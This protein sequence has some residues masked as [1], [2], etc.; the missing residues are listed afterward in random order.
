VSFSCSEKFVHSI[1]ERSR[2]PQHTPDKWRPSMASPLLWDKT[3]QNW[4]AQYLAGSEKPDVRR[5]RWSCHLTHLNLLTRS[6]CPQ[7][8]NDVRRRP[9]YTMR[10]RRSSCPDH[11]SPS[12]R[13]PRSAGQCHRLAAAAGKPSRQYDEDKSADC[14]NAVDC[15]KDNQ[16]YCQTLISS[17]WGYHNQRQLAFNT[18][19][20]TVCTNYL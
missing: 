14:G 13:I 11:D 8:V 12:T 7:R 3:K 9:S 19:P 5:G 4:G 20:F 6:S 18:V 16:S 17:R 10:L 1:P 15:T 2:D